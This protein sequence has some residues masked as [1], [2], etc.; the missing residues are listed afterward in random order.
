MKLDLV[1][2]ITNYFDKIGVGVLEVSSGTVKVG[3][4]LLIGEEGEGFEQVVSSMQIEHEPVN[5]V[6]AGDDCGI[7]L[8][9]E[10]KKGSKVYKI[11][12]E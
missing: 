3:D 10:T 8:D 6:K 11:V 2:K 9:Q 4:K 7:K 12:E 1:G 5:E